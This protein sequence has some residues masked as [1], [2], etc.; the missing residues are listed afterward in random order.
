MLVLSRKTGERIR[1]E[2]HLEITVLGIQKGRVK[3]G[4]TGPPAV[5]I[6]RDEMVGSHHRDGARETSDERR[7]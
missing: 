7:A 4:F 5:S 6:R 1:I 3:L 2:P